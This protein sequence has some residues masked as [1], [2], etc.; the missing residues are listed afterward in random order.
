MNRIT[1]RRSKM[2]KSLIAAA[3]VISSSFLGSIANASVCIVGQ[4][5]EVGTWV[6]QDSNTRGVT[7]VIFGEECRDASTVKCNGDIC[8]ITSAVKLVY[9]ARVWGKCHPTDCYWG[10]VD[11]KYT[12]AK[13]L[14]FYYDP[15]F[16][17]KTVWGQIKSGDNN[18]LRLVVDTYFTDSS[19]RKDY[20]T[21]DWMIRR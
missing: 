21:D 15:G 19:G 11:G 16:A 5:K 3:V 1:I 10:K 12:S 4:V 17:K 6:N 2:I 9:T 13:W 8:S 20:Q 14:R 18:K 7:K